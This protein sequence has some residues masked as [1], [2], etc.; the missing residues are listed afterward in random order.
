ML[1]TSPDRTIGMATRESPTCRPSDERSAMNAVVAGHVVQLCDTG[2]DHQHAPC[3][4]LG[5]PRER[6]R[7]CSQK[8]NRGPHPAAKEAGC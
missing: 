1:G 4:M 5:V 7:F 3:P 6:R 8:P 2:H